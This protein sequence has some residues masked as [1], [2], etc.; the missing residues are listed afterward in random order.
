MLYFHGINRFLVASIGY[1]GQR[2]LR[3]D[4]LT[5]IRVTIIRGLAWAA[6]A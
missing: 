6:M 2:E 5:D 3:K 1:K 4:A